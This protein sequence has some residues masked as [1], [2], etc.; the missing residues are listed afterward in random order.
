MRR[1][2][3][4]GE[5]LKSLSLDRGA[6]GSFGTCTTRNMR[7]RVPNRIQ[8]TGRATVPGIRQLRWGSGYLLINLK[9]GETPNI[10]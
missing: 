7:N 5:L 2:W 8:G 6:L 1:Q 10:N 4:Y 9:I 3:T